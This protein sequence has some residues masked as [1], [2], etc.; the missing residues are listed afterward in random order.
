MKI[1]S[2]AR[3]WFAVVLAVAWTVVAVMQFADFS[4]E[5]A[6]MWREKANLILPPLA[7]AMIALNFVLDR[8]EREGADG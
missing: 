5:P 8:K 4:G 2:R 7:L 1:S 3:H 6:P